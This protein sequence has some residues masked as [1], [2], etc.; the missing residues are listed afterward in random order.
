MKQV[1]IKTI[2]DDNFILQLNAL[3]S[4]FRNTE[5]NEK[6]EFNLE[7][8]CWLCPIV[9]LPVS[10]YIQKTDS[11]YIK[12]SQET[13]NAYLNAICFPRGVNSVTNFEKLLQDKK[14]YTP[15]SVLER[16]KE[17]EREDLEGMFS[18]MIYKLLGSTPGIQSAIYQPIAEL[19]T[20]IFEHSGDD[21]GFIFGQYYPSKKF[22]DICIVD[23]GRGLAKTYEEAK[24]LS[25]T[26]EQAIV[27]VLQGH[28]TKNSN[29]RG[30]GIRTSKNIVCKCFDGH[31]AIISG[32]H[33]FVASK[34]KE[35]LVALPNFYWQG[36]IISYRINRP[37][38]AIDITKYLE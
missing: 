13:V 1:K 37:S 23:R 8:A 34:D 30:F 14:S 12:S 3:Y 31:F 18:G 4:I 19:V 16:N 7:Q 35:Q 11:E 22:L 21:R 29:E 17:A 32:S 2:K 6:I 5:N 10:A 27:E 24:N 38:G 25:L 15:I 36:V 20:N 28:S 33:A 9:L 26:D